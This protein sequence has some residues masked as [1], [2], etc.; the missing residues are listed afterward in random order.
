MELE[1]RH[2]AGQIDDA[3]YQAEQ[4]RLLQELNQ[5]RSDDQQSGR[6]Q[7]QTKRSGP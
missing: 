1:L 7:R 5:M 4:S 6:A 2:K 3:E